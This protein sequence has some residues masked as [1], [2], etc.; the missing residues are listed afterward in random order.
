[1]NAQPLK[2]LVWNVRGLNNPARR[3]AIAQ[4]V[5]EA[6]PAIV[7]FQET[8]MELVTL[9]IVKHCLGNKFEEFFYLPAIGTRGGILLAC[10]ATVVAL[11]HP[12][13]T[14]NTLSALVKPCEGQ[15]WWITG[16]YGPQLDAE[17]IEFM[18]EIVDV[19]ELQAGPWMIVGNFNLLVNQEDKSNTSIN[20]RMMARFWAKLNLLELKEL[21]L[22]GRR[23]TW[24][25]ERARA[26][27]EK[28][29]HVFCT[30]SWEDLHPTCYLTALGSAISD[31]CPMLLDMNADLV[32][33][34]RF[35]F[36]SFWTKAEGFLDTVSSAWA[37][38]PSEGNPFV[39]LDLKLRA[40]TKALKKWSD[41]CIGN[42]KM[43]I[44]IALEVILCL[45]KAMDCRPLCPL[46]FDLRKLLKRKLLGLRSLERTITRQ[47]SCL[48][49]LHEGDANTGFF[50]S[51]ARQ[52]QR[53]NMITSLRH[54]STIATG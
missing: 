44:A 33:G 30:N 22:N 36:E 47:R 51:H 9:D 12:H 52:R 23:Y 48:L 27:L 25:N 40:T 43:Q 31:H 32:M 1:M 7:C 14:S 6:N 5:L 13:Y 4:V 18:Q 10:D 45:D 16:V 17:K 54:G 8:K 46:E 50:H 38:V 42:I 24:S 28:I 15:E 26:T 11:S 41:R 2:M 29:D 34:H 49:F 35:K 53:R 39:V 21:Y 37:S 19:R 20:R 3:T